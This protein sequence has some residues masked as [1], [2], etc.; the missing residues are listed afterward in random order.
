MNT[1]LSS[2][3]EQ[4]VQDKIASGR[5][6]SA[7]DVIGTALEALE[8][9]DSALDTRAQTFRSEI[10]HRL[11]SGPATPMDFSEIKKRIRAELAAEMNATR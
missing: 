2:D 7:E 6:R 4:R 8:A 3:L 10:E 11:Q 5:Y 1:R 9:Q